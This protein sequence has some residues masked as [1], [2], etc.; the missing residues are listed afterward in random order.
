MIIARQETMEAGNRNGNLLIGKP[1]KSE[2]K[3]SL[4]GYLSDSDMTYELV[5]L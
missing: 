2:A 3:I 5:E 1:L 4:Q